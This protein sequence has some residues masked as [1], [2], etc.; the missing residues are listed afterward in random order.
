M[1]RIIAA[2]TA[3]LVTSVVQ[4]Q[5]F[6]CVGYDG[7]IS[8]SQTPCPATQGDA[9]WAG[10]T[11]PTP[12]DGPV[13]SSDEIVNRN[14]RAASI[15]GNEEQKAQI[16]AKRKAAEQ[17]EADRA[18]LELASQPQR[19]RTICND[20][21]T[22]TFCRSSDG[23]KSV[24]NRIGNASFTRTKDADGNVTRTTKQRL[25]NTAIINTTEE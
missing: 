10:N 8:F 1:I 3:L 19:V 11:I 9:S 25:G 12:E 13:E 23:S 14:L 7:S 20:L 24:T 5:I 16:A 15:I 18:A 2:T 4:A 17:E 6:K 21:G 22:S